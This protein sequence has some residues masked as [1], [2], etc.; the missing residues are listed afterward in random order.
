M[1]V[2]ASAH[3]LL[4]H[5]FAQH[6]LQLLQHKIA[7]LAV[8]A[9]SLEQ[10]FH[11]LLLSIG[12][13]HLVGTNLEKRAVGYLI[14][15]S[16]RRVGHLLETFVGD[17][18]STALFRDVTICIGTGVHHCVDSDYIGPDVIVSSLI[19]LSHLTVQ[20]VRA[21]GLSMLLTTCP[22]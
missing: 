10:H 8:P 12:F 17:F 5:V 21:I 14:R 13:G 16:I 2:N 18:H 3:K 4:V 22:G 19:Q 15:H 20:V 11:N 6:G 9:A 7:H 1:L